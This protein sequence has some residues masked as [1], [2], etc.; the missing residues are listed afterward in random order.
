MASISKRVL[1]D[2]SVRWLGQIRKTKFK[3]VSVWKMTKK[4]LEAEVQRIELAMDNGTWDEFTR[5]EQ[6][7]GKTNLAHFIHKYLREIT[8]H[9]AGGAKTITDRKSVV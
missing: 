1:K 3:A 9:K 7:D 4:A 2:G 8:P 5:S 6:K